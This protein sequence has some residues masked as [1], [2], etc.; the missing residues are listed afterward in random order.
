MV[1]LK[2]QE[3]CLLESLLEHLKAAG[4]GSEVDIDEVLSPD[5]YVYTTYDQK[6]IVNRG[7]IYLI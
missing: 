4:D 6:F 5:G 7:Y 1:M 3:L 2:K